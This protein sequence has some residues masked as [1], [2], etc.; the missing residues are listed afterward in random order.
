VVLR[1]LGGLRACGG[2]LLSRGGG[3][4]R[5]YK[6]LLLA[7]CGQSQSNCG[8][9]KAVWLRDDGAMPVAFEIDEVRL[10]LRPLL[11]AIV[12]LVALLILYRY[13]YSHYPIVHSS[14]NALSV[15]KLAIS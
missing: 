15:S 10:S 8:T 9:T 11:E 4:T 7:S 3:A 14:L 12:F 5:L 6:R 13:P 1:G 2:L